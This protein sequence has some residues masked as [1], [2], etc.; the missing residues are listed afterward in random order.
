MT[1]IQ[2]MLYL[3]ELLKNALEEV[4]QLKYEVQELEEELR[5]PIKSYTEKDFESFVG[6]LAARINESIYIYENMTS[7][8][9][10]IEINTLKA[11]LE[12]IKHAKWRK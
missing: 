6:S 8:D 11:V 1:D 10:H 3:T 4:I 7:G 9:R 2:A 12:I 5:K